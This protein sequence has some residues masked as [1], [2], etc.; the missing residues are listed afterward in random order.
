MNITLNNSSV[1]YSQIN[2]TDNYNILKVIDQSGGTK[3]RIT[4]TL[5]PMVAPTNDGEVSVSINDGVVLS[6]TLVQNARGRNFYIKSNSSTS[7]AMSLAKALRSVPNVSSLYDVICSNVNTVTLVARKYGAISSEFST[8]NTAITITQTIGSSNSS[9]ENGKVVADVFTGNKYIT[10]M[11]KNYYE[12]EVAFDLSSVLSTFSEYG[13]LKPYNVKLYGALSD[14]SFTTLGEKSAY[15]G[16]GYKVNNS[17]DF[18]YL[19]GITLAQYV[20]DGHSNSGKLNT[21]LLY[22]YQPYLNFSLFNSNL[23][24]TSITINYLD[25]ADNLIYG[26]QEEIVFN[27]YL[28]DFEYILNTNYFNQAF[29]IEVVIPN[30]GTLRYNVIKPLN[31][32]DTNQRVYW[33]NEYGGVSFFDFTSHKEEERSMELETY[34]KNNFDYY[35][36]EYKDKEK[37]YENNSRLNITLTSH[38]ISKDGT[39]I[40]NSM[41]KSR[42]VWTKID[43]II[44]EIIIDNV[45]IEET[46]IDGIFQASVTYHYSV[47]NF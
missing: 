27:N 19:N 1:P 7:T 28:E 29:Y 37:V 25:S 38:L 24:T 15:I 45:S 36:S 9:L 34:T 17:S 33:R 18:L 5:L 42:K 20:E 23:I 40:F 2:F 8:N 35:E 22:M 13:E 41:A 4:I 10:S 43:G 30:L 44:Y 31:M 6:T 47:N 21:S 46:D 11:E 26:T 14:G 39:Y 16:Y 3:S 32:T 12:S